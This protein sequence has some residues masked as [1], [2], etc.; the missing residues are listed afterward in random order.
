MKKIIRKIKLFFF[1]RKHSQVV[2]TIAEKQLKLRLIQRHINIYNKMMEH[3]YLGDNMWEN[4][5]VLLSNKGYVTREIKELK[6]QY[7]NP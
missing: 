7:F 6:R 2:V 3:G 1:P 5:H 4:Y